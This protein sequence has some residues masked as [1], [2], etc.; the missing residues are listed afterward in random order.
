MAPEANESARRVEPR[1]KGDGARAEVIAAAADEPAEGLLAKK[2]QNIP[3]GSW[4]E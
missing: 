3:I 1:A 2:A 4:L